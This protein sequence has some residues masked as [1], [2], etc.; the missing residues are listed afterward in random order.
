[1]VFRRILY[2]VKGRQ[3]EKVGHTT[4]KKQEKEKLEAE[5]GIELGN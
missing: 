3:Q 5:E 1:M 2:L 4:K